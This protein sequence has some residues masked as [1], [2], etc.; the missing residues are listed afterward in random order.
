MKCFPILGSDVT[1]RVKLDS[2]R[3][4]SQTFEEL[5]P[6]LPEQYSVH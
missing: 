3:N 6:R 5:D 2:V 1:R 4:M